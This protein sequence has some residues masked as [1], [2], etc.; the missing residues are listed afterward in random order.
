MTITRIIVAH[1]WRADP[2][3]HWF[4]WL[5]TVF[6]KEGKE[7]TIPALPSPLTPKRHEWVQCLTET[8]GSPDEQTAIVGH[9]LGCITALHVL[10]NVSKE[11]WKLGALI[12]VSGFDSPLANIPE[13]DEFTTN[14]NVNMTKIMDRTDLRAVIHSDNDPLVAPAAS[15]SLAQKLNASVIC[16]KGA[17]HFMDKEG[18]QPRITEVQEV[19]DLIR[20][21]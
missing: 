15:L 14:C 4:P 3:K 19:A 5:R 12:C 8:I 10:N 9:S 6:E 7:V 13:L 16:V 2:S 17:G 20:S 21:M 18:V 11:D 1:G